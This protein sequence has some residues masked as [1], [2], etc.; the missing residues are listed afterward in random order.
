MAGCASFAILFLRAI[1]D[2]KNSPRGKD[3]ESR[4]QTQ[5]KFCDCR[6]ASPLFVLKIVLSFTIKYPQIQ[7]NIFGHEELIL[8]IRLG[9]SL[10]RVNRM[11]KSRQQMFVE[12]QNS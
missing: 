1:F 12:F 6:S 3:S 10:F 11:C 2:L 7:K 8:V 5:I 4:V 9:N